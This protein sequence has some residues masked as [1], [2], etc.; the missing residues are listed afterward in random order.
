MLGRHVETLMNTHGSEYPY[1]GLPL[2]PL[3]SN[4]AVV[5]NFESAIAKV[6]QQTPASNLKFSVDQAH[7]EAFSQQ[8]THASLGNNHSLDYGPEGYQTAVDTL[9]RFKV[10]PFGHNAVISRDSLTYI[11]TDRGRLALLGIN[12][13]QRIPAT[14]EIDSLCVS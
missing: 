10:V 2:R 5:G 13:S 1:Q 14:E 11:D 8:F 4:P 7:L 3:S 12:A 6:H 9:E